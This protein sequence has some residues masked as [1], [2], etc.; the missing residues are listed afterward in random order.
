MVLLLIHSMVAG[1]TTSILVTIHSSE[2]A[3]ALRRRPL[4]VR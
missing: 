4:H 1:S 3:F 2:F